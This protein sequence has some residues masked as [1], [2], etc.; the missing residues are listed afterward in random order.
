MLDVRKFPKGFLLGSSGSAYQYEGAW[1]EDGKG[2][3]IWDVAVHEKPSRIQDGST[4]DVACD[5]YHLYKEDVKIMSY[6]GLDFFRF[7]F[8]W[9]RILPTGFPNCINQAGID[10]YNNFI[11]ELIKHNVTPFATIY[12]WDLPKQLQELGGWTN[13]DVVQWFVDYA[14]VLFDNFGH[15]V[16]IWATINE[17]SMI[18][19]GGYGAGLL[20]PFVNAYGI[21]E[22]ACAEHVLLAHAKTYR[23]YHEVYKGK[24]KVGIVLNTHWFEPVTNSKEDKKAVSDIIQFELGI[25]ANPIYDPCGDYPEVVKK[26]VAAKSSEQGFPRSRLPKL[27]YRDLKLIKG[28]ADF[29]GINMYSTYFVYRN[30]SVKGSYHVPSS[31]DDLEVGFSITQRPFS[32]ATSTNPRDFYKLLVKIKKLY[33]NPTVYITENGLSNDGGLEDDDRIEYIAGHINALLDAVDQGCDVRAYSVWSLLDNFEWLFGYKNKYGLY[34]VDFSSPKRTRT[35]RK[36]AHFYRNVTQS[37]SI[38]RCDL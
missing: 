25:Y 18:C 23:L 26:R 28:S 3:S 22:Y 8:S 19:L 13:P 14:K 21:G 31:L 15:K 7:S 36:S 38:E 6:V 12:H 35:P 30:E 2:P 1:N 16:K 17:P 20:A 4:G 10:F 9:S 29:L 11:D 27:S 24:G 37:R 32:V 5:S 33:N 34:E